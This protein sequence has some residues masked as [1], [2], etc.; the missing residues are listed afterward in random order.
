MDIPFVFGAVIIV[1]VTSGAGGLWHVRRRRRQPAKRAAGTVTADAMTTEEKEVA[2]ELVKTAVHDLLHGVSGQVD[3]MQGDSHRYGRALEV[4]RES[5]ERMATA[6][7]LR[8]MEQR[9]LEQ[10]K[11]IQGANDRY[12]RELDAANTRVAE[13][14]KELERLHHAAGVDFLTELPNRR[15]L[16]ERLRE[17]FGR[18]KRY[19]QHFSIIILDIDHFKKVNDEHGHPA[20]DRVLRA[21][22]RILF[23]QKRAS[24]FLARYGGEEF[25]MLLPET[26]LESAS[27]LA[28]KLCGIIRG[29]EFQ[30]QKQKV[31]ITLSAG[32]G[33]VVPGVDTPES[34]FE[35]VDA[36]LYRAK[37]EGRDR[38]CESRSPAA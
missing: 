32:V 11:T 25:V 6:E 1:L 34:L 22:A 10:V 26:P 33:E 35:R 4:H 12:R 16:D 23:D 7:D 36:A 20:G 31:Q 21:I 19:G 14:Q 3:A 15:Q 18:A 37:R 28:V 30:F 38:V 29:T 9:L 27:L 24:D 5:L 13:Q 8:E 2:L 17:E